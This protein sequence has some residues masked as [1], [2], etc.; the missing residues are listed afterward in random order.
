MS[1]ANI[2]LK[3]QLT[4]QQMVMLQSEFDR[5]KK[6]KGAAYAFWFFLGAFGGHRFYSRDTKRAICM[7]L[8][9]GGLGFWAFF[10]VFFIGSRIE[11]LNDE[12]EAELIQNI[13]L[14]TKQ[15]QP[16]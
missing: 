16:N 2:L 9:L 12:I 8:T 14:L 6:S 13:Q 15:E 7:L 1:T 3:Q 10:D 5:K 4:P 11:E